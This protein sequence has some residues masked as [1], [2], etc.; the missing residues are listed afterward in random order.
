ML[1]ALTSIHPLTSLFGLYATYIGSL[2]HFLALSTFAFCALQIDWQKKLNQAA[3]YI[4]ASATIASI[5]A[6]VQFGQ[7]FFNFRELYRVRSTI[8][9]PN[10]LAFFLAASLPFSLFL[11]VKTKRGWLKLAGFASSLLIFITI[12]LTLSRASW[13]ALLLSFITL[14]LIYFKTKPKYSLKNFIQ[15]NKYYLIAILLLAAF[16]WPFL[17]VKILDRNLAV[18][19]DLKIGGGSINL[20]LQNWQAVWQTIKNRESWHQHFLGTGPL[21]IAYTYLKNRPVFLNQNPIE[22]NWNTTIVRNQFLDY[23]ANLGILGLFSFLAI[24]AV[25]F[26]QIAKN[27]KTL[28]KNPAFWLAASSFSI[29]LFSSLFYYQTITTSIYFWFNL[30]LLTSILPKQKI[31][32]KKAS[33]VLLVSVFV[34]ASS[35]IILIKIIFADFAFSKGNFKEAVQINPYNNIYKRQLVSSLIKQVEDN[36]DIEKA[37]QAIAEA[38]KAVSINPASAGNQYALQLANYKTGVL[39]DKGFHQKALAAGEKRLM[40]DP[41][42]A[43]PYDTQGL[44]YLDTG[45]LKKAL[46]YFK[47]A[48]EIDP[49]NLESYLHCGEALKQMG[50]I[51][52]A[53]NYYN[54]ALEKNPSWPFAREELQKA[55]SLLDKE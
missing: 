41:S 10:R 21:T 53:I 50:K 5:F 9:E 15:G 43:G 13:L 35:L 8:G 31:N 47:K 37:K 30:G 34:T 26:S 49:E 51:E 4:S 22:K 36:K 42:H 1:S 6:L 38:E 27:L 54:L 55:K 46:F 29:I 18:L 24:L 16:S 25:L 45:E 40:L 20:R 12:L 3:V 33:F 44:V 52:E 39:F 23:L 48:L 2:I 28:A 17:G 7:Y 14:S 32:L 11:F 19:R